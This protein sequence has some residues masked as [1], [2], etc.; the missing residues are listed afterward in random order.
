MATSNTKLTKEQK[1][2]GERDG[3]SWHVILLAESSIY[4]RQ[5]ATLRITHT[6][7]TVVV[8]SSSSQGVDVAIRKG[9]DPIPTMLETKPSSDCRRAAF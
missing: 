4:C 2:K 3:R 7:T 9:A 5:R 8:A 6:P 1:Q